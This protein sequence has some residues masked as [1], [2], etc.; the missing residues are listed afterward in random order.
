MSTTN[1][2]SPACTN[3][4]VSA[5]PGLG[6]GDLDPQIATLN[7][8]SLGKLL[9]ALAILATTDAIILS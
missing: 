1:I 7:A 5:L 3:M 2:S 4:Q 6:I 8:S 9:V